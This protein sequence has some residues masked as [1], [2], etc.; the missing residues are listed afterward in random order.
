MESRTPNQNQA[1]DMER[2]AYNAA[3]HDLG[4]RWHWDSE[5]YT[6][7]ISRPSTDADRVEHYLTTRHPHL[8]KAYDAAFL[9]GAI[10]HR[11]AQFKNRSTPVPTGRRF[12]WSAMIGSEIGV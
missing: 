4:L 8:L 2:D 1:D 5:T 11:R 6:D 10:E 12:D 9:V 7:L 3:F